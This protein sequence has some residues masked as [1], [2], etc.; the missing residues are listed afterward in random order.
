MIELCDLFD[1]VILIVCIKITLTLYT[2]YRRGVFMRYRKQVESVLRL[3]VFCVSA[4]ESCKQ[5]LLVKLRVVVDWNF[6]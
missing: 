6:S 2:Y 3:E 4:L 1:D 5:I